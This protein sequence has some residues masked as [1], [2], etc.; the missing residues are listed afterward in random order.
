VAVE[1]FPEPPSITR[2]QSEAAKPFRLHVAG[3]HAETLEAGYRL[4]AD[5]PHAHEVTNG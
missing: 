5:C 3:P 2:E 4:K 1:E